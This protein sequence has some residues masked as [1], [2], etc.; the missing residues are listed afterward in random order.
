MSGRVIDVEIGL[1]ECYIGAMN[2]DER[3]TP[4]T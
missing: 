3:D 4:R 2:D 1:D